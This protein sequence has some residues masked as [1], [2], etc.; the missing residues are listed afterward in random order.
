M[1]F[2]ELHR[3]RRLLQLLVGH[4]GR[5]RERW[6]RL[7]EI[8]GR[9]LQHRG[10]R[11]DIVVATK[12]RAAMGIEFSDHRGTAAQREGLSRRWIMRAC[13]D[14]P[15]AGGVLTGKYQREKALPASVRAEENAEVRFSE[16]NWH[17]LE[18][19]IEVA[20]TVG[21]TPASTA[22][23][24]LRSKPWVSAPIVGAN[25]PDQLTE[26]LRGLDVSLEADALALLDDASDFG[27]SRPSLET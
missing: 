1:T 5:S 7:G 18:T 4:D 26:A 21:Q 10:N 11:D 22:I 23:N 17:I 8:V 6:R 15:L 12:V 13:E 9:W 25:R 20:A 14:S 27:R 16:K 24:W 3:H 19:L 2:G